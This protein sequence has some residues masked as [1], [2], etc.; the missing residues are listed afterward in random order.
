MTEVRLTE[1][2]RGY[3]VY[4]TRDY[5]RGDVIIGDEPPWI[6]VR[7]GVSLLNGDADAFYRERAAR[8]AAVTAACMS[9][10]DLR[11]EDAELVT[12]TAVRLTFRALLRAHGD[13][14]RILA[15]FPH[16]RAPRRE[17]MSTECARSL[18]TLARRFRTREEAVVRVYYAVRDHAFDLHSQISSTRIGCSALYER[19]T[20]CN[21][22]CVPNASFDFDNA[23]TITVF[24]LERIARGD[25]VTISYTGE[26][27]EA[28]AVAGDDPVVGNFVCRC[29][30]HR[31]IRADLL[32]RQPTSAPPSP[33]SPLDAFIDEVVALYVQ[34]RRASMDCDISDAYAAQQRL[35]A[36][37][38]QR[39]DAL[40]AVRG[41]V[42]RSFDTRSLR[43][44]NRLFK[45][46]SVTALAVE[47]ATPQV[48]D[49]FRSIVVPPTERLLLRAE[50]R[51]DTLQYRADLH[52]SRLKHLADFALHLTLR[53]FIGNVD[54]STP[55]VTDARMRD[56]LQGFITALG[57]RSDVR[58]AD[59][60]IRWSETEATPQQRAAAALAMQ[61]HMS[62]HSGAAMNEMRRA[63]DRCAPL[64]GFVVTTWYGGDA[65]AYVRR[66]ADDIGEVVFPG[67]DCKRMIELVS[68][69]YRP[70]STLS[71]SRS[72]T[73]V[74]LL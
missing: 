70:Q 1:D 24:A 14:A 2:G 11:F 35:N 18:H 57:E 53:C 71:G 46:Y 43:A 55:K 40:A 37:F 16:D 4:A 74:L 3:G 45:L 49:R 44:L 17:S 65:A 12:D 21:H 58:T 69:S 19:A 27:D 60:L 9:A 13:V 42:V 25:E 26:P 72:N 31:E 5:K 41:D 29:A 34:F 50:H 68:D 63:A 38:V 73:P 20:R 33:P 59:D 23:W 8:E 6:A 7:S 66:W 10:D 30:G 64:F 32:L 36:L 22:R 48:R 56:A 67:T 54:A 15:L 39:V 62:S 61:W 51:P 52:R 28:A 47:F